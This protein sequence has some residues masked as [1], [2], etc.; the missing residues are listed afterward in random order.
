MSIQII[1]RIEYMHLR[2]IKFNNGLDGKSVPIFGWVDSLVCFLAVEA[3]YFAAGCLFIYIPN[4]Y[5]GTFS[6]AEEFRDL[7]V[8]FI[9][10]QRLEGLHITSARSYVQGLERIG[11]EPHTQQALCSS[12]Y[13]F[14]KLSPETVLAMVL[15][16]LEGY[17]KGMPTTIRIATT[18]LCLTEFPGRLYLWRSGARCI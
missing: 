18:G 1:R 14:P 8:V 17:C 3:D 2:G 9:G 5:V 16:E 11:I 4:K 7:F 10:R 13:M 6:R 12:R 15:T